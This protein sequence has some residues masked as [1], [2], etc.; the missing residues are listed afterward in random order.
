MSLAGLTFNPWAS[1]TMLANVPLPRFDP[2]HVVPM[3]LCKLCQ[4]FLSQVAFHSQLAD[5]PSQIDSGISD[6]AEQ[7]RQV[8]LQPF[9]N[10]LDI[11]ERYLPDAALDPAV[12]RAVQP[13]PLGSLLLIDLLF[14]PYASNGATETDAD[15]E[16]H[17]A[18]I[19]LVTSRCVHTR[20][21]TSLLTP[22]V[23]SVSISPSP[24][25]LRTFAFEVRMSRH[26]IA[27]CALLLPLSIAAA[28][29]TPGREGV[30][31]EVVATATEY[32]PQSTT[33]SHPGHAYT[34]CLG[35]TSYF[36]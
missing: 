25:A 36:G 11:H 35:S 34:N 18:R 13:A 20:W 27:T 1:F 10:L 29:Q 9:G 17:C 5:A 21:V 12:V 28:Q 16:R 33:V 3:Q 14:L 6:T 23:V 8:F 7:V 15:V 32:V 2:A 30:R 4:L 26:T 22:T 31:V 19:L 24:I